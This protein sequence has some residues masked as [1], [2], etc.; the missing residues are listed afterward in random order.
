MNSRRRGCSVYWRLHVTLVF[1]SLTLT[2]PAL[3]GSDYRDALVLALSAKEKALDSNR[4]E[5]W[6]EALQLLEQADSILATAATKYEIGC[7][8]AQ[9]EQDDIAVENY[10]MALR[11]G[12]PEK[13]SQKARTFIKTHVAQL[14]QLSIEGPAG[15]SVFL[16]GV[17]RGRLPLSEFIFVKPGLVELE[18]LTLENLSRHEILVLE[19]GRITT[20]LLRPDDLDD[21]SSAKTLEQHTKTA[22][23]APAV[24]PEPVI[25]ATHSIDR[26]NLSQSRWG[27]APAASHQHNSSWRST[28]WLLMGAGST[29]S[30]LSAVFVPIANKMVSSSRLA[31]RDACN[32]QFNGPDSCAHSK[33]GRLQEAQ[34]AS[35]SI[36]TWKMA[37]TVSW[38]GLGA[39]LSAAIS[40][41]VLVLTADTH[42][43]VSPAQLRYSFEPHSVEFSYQAQF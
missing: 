33:P 42:R 38:V 30:V 23:E 43:E 4:A 32:P 22:P 27:D 3:A 1:A 17:Q 18:A 5:D 35:D 25:P 29:V 14:A 21:S 34:S 15:T 7:A 39:G 24:Q 12:L 41:A 28:G 11:L 31:L 16:G 40:G 6:T 20:T 13:A 37:R 10:Q 2:L 19:A 26:E 36:A 9:L 8:A